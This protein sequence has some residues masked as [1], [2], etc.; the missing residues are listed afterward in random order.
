MVSVSRLHGS[1]YRSA[2]KA[3]AIDQEIL[4]EIVGRFS[5]SVA[6]F[7]PP[8][9]RCGQAVRPEEAVRLV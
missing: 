5:C 9:V 6:G 7:D 8:V 1:T 2:T 3:S 4:K